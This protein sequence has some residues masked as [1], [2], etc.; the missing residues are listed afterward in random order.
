LN[1]FPQSM[2]S[3]QGC[4]LVETVVPEDSQQKPCPEDLRQQHLRA[5]AAMPIVASIDALLA[6][7]GDIC[8]QDLDEQTAR[9]W[10]DP[11]LGEGDFAI[12][13]GAYATL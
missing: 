6:R 10:Y 9:G 2:A 1:S 3:P 11:R 4:F 5:P 13:R 7:L 8:T 12:A